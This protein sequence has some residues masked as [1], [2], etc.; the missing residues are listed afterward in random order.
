MGKA[1]G[2]VS[3]D[4]M[5]RLMAWRW[6][7]NVRELQN[8]IER[9][10]TLEIE[11]HIQPESLPPALLDQPASAAGLASALSLEAGQVD[12]DALLAEVE[13]NALARAL[14]RSGGNRTEAA[15]ILGITF[16][17]MRYRLA[18]HGLADDDDA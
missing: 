3:R 2:G 1:V 11:E 12:L 18:K 8:V 4:A 17:S 10:M 13:R 5:Q 14:E 16:R 15:R 9:A 6:D 7:G